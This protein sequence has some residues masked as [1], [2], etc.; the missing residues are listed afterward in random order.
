MTVG[1]TAIGYDTVIIGGLYFDGTGAPASIKNVAIKDGKISQVTTDELSL[2][3]NPKVIEANG[4]WVTP[5]FLD[6]HTHYDAELMVSP[7]LSESVRHGVTTVLVGSC[8]LSM[9]CSD[10]EDASDIFTRVETVP[11]EKVLPILQQKK[12]WNSPK[13]WID[14]IAQQPL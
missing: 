1:K 7:S 2:D 3:G 6:T 9:I 10:A 14:Y 5:G 11:R 12:T 8:S 13:G 4:K